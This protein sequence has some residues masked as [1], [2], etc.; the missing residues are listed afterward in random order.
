LPTVAARFSRRCL[1]GLPCQVVEELHGRGHRF[2]PP[3]RQRVLGSGGRGRGGKQGL[4]RLSSLW[5]RPGVAYAQPCPA[6]L[7]ITGTVCQVI[8]WRLDG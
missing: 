2:V 8:G 3:Q 5:P 1:F 6:L 4:G 7:M